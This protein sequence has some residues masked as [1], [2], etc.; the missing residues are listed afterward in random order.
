VLLSALGVAFLAAGHSIG[1]LF[2]WRSD[3][4]AFDQLMFARRAFKG[5]VEPELRRRSA[6]TTRRSSRSSTSSR[7][8]VGVRC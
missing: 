5:V 2:F 7:R 8:I 1:E 3:R 6:T 4:G